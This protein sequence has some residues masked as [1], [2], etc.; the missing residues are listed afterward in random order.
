MSEKHRERVTNSLEPTEEQ[1]V[2]LAHMLNMF[3]V[4]KE[5]CEGDAL[6]AW[7]LIR[8]MVLEEAAVEC[9]TAGRQWF[10][11]P[12]HEASRLACEGCADLLRKMMGASPGSRPTA[13]KSPPA[14]PVSGSE[15]A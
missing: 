12:G 8:D 3:A 15:G 11:Q 13:A 14:A 9:D 6:V 7:N 1:L 2:V 10:G 4:P 5:H